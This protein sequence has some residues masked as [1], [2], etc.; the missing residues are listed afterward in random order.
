VSRGHPR[1]KTVTIPLLFEG[2]RI[3]VFWLRLDDFHGRVTLLIPPIDFHA[4]WPV[5]HGQGADMEMLPIHLELR[6]CRGRAAIREVGCL[7]DSPTV[8]LLGVCITDHIFPGTMLSEPLQGSG[9]KETFRI[10]GGVIDEAES[11]QLKALV[12][13][14]RVILLGCCRAGWSGVDADPDQ[15]WG[16]HP[17]PKQAKRLLVLDIVVLRVVPT[18]Q[19]LLDPI[20]KFDGLD[21]IPLECH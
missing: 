4:I 18:V 9:D 1:G 10:L 20:G 7:V 8:P 17:F 21:K 6:G 13:V 14:F 16:E 5:Q 15:L 19:K 2:K 11:P 3:N 12:R